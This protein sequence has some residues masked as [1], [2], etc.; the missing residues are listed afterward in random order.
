[1]AK[2]FLYFIMLIHII[3]RSKLL[4][5]AQEMVDSGLKNFRFDCM[6]PTAPEMAIPKIKSYPHNSNA[7]K[8]FVIIGFNHEVNLNETCKKCNIS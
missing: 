3:S 8:V 2:S 6:R 5:S 1:M 7:A 4:S